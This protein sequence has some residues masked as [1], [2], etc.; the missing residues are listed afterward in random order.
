MS[1]HRDVADCELTII[2]C[3]VDTPGAGGDLVLFPGRTAEPLETVRAT[4][5]HGAVTLRLAP[6]ESLFFFGSAV[7]HGV[8]PVAP[9][10]TRITASLCYQRAERNAQRFRQCTS[11]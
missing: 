8:T 7:P 9:G 1:L 10:R 4:P 3:I 5:E 6:G 2:T 11:F